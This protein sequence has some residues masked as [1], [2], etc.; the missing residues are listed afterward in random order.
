M[1]LPLGSTGQWATLPT[2]GAARK[3]LA[4][5]TGVDPT[6][7]GKSYVYS[8]FGMNATTTNNNYEYLSITTGANG[9]Q[10]AGGAWTTGTSTTAA[11]RWQAGAWHVDSTVYGP[12]GTSTHVY[13]GGGLTAGGMA[14]NTVEAGKIAA[15]GDLGTLVVGAGGGPVRNFGVEIAG[16]G[17]CAANNQ[18]FTFGGVGGGPAKNAKSATLASPQPA[19][20][21]GAW[22]DEGLSTIDP[23][24]LEGS[25]V[26]SAFIFLLGGETSA[27]PPI[28]AT[29]NTETVVW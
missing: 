4:M 25:A 16:Y 9:H 8:F 3:G 17:V 12:A 14:A 21:A 10:T 7:P 28:V 11:P 13:V 20:A 27:G 29:K 1:P 19:L 6:T 5:T 22:N 2:M 18:L 24:Y 23:L 15:G 26:Q